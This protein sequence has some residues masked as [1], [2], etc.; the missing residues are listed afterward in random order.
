MEE[1]EF[2]DSGWD[3]DLKKAHRVLISRGPAQATPNSA[4]CPINADTTLLDEEAAWPVALP[5]R[6]SAPF[7]ETRAW[8]CWTHTQF[9]ALSEGGRL[10]R[11]R[12]RRSQLWNYPITWNRHD[13]SADLL[14]HKAAAMNNSASSAGLHPHHPPWSLLSLAFSLISYFLAGFKYN[15]TWLT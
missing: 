9:F 7:C 8:H 1:K 6:S 3:S 13:T 10:G 4:M 12:K 11:D 15:F 2:A 14:C 5:R